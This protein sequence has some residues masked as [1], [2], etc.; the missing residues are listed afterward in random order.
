MMFTW[1]HTQHVQFVELLSKVKI[2]SN[3]SLCNNNNIPL[4]ETEYEWWKKRKCKWFFSFLC[5]FFFVLIV[6][7]RVLFPIVLL[8][9]STV[10]NKFTTICACSTKSIEIFFSNSRSKEILRRNN[11][12]KKMNISAFFFSPWENQ[13]CQSRRKLRNSSCKLIDSLLSNESSLH[14]LRISYREQEIN[15]KKKPQ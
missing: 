7:S 13:K 10:S 9:G 15:G 8:N 1:N 3:I 5:I 14:L 2:N 6:D 11:Y 12:W 4:E